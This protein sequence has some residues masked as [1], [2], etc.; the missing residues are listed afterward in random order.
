MHVHEDNGV[1]AFPHRLNSV[2]GGLG[3]KSKGKK[4]RPGCPH[5]A[6]RTT[7]QRGLSCTCY[8]KYA[9]PRLVLQAL[10]GRA[11]YFQLPWLRRPSR[12]RAWAQ[13]RAPRV[14]FRAGRDPHQ[15]Q[16]ADPGRPRGRRP[17]RGAGG[18]APGVGCRCR[19]AVGRWRGAAQE[20]S[21]GGGTVSRFGK[22]GLDQYK[23]RFLKFL[24]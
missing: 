11:G 9:V 20:S 10:G 14:V 7:K 24:S 4:Q 5:C 12:Q 22:E 16:I 21:K 2:P 1:F 6:T 19:S 8:F 17:G 3:R 23:P 13:A 15:G 18:P